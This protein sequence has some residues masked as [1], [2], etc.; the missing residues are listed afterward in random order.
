MRPSRRTPLPY[1]EAFLERCKQDG[2]YDD[3]EEVTVS[4]QYDNENKDMNNDNDE[5]VIQ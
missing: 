5:P 3:G 4:S 1:W 2:V